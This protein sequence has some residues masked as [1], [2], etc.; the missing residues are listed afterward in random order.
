MKMKIVKVIGYY[1][2]IT[3]IGELRL[4]NIVVGK[5]DEKPI[6]QFVHP[7]FYEGLYKNKKKLQLVVDEMKEALKDYFAVVEPEL[8]KLKDRK[9]DEEVKLVEEK[10]MDLCKLRDEYLNKEVEIEFV[11]L[12]NIP[13]GVITSM[14]DREFLEPLL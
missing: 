4:S 13:C 10:H 2:A 7:N 1:N 14:G 11:K 8:A 9:N 12:T 6:I 3:A 5:D